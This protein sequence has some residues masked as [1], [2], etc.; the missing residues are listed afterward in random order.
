MTHPKY[1]SLYLQPDVP[2]DLKQLVTNWLESRKID[3]GLLPDLLFEFVCVFNLELTEKYSLQKKMLTM[4]DIVWVLSFIQKTIKLA[5]NTIEAYGWALWIMVVEGAA[6]YSLPHKD[7]EALTIQLKELIHRQ[8]GVTNV[9]SLE[10]LS[11]LD[12]PL[13]I[14]TDLPLNLLGLT[15]SRRIFFNPQTELSDLLG[16][17]R[18]EGKTFNWIDGDLLTAVK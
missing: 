14:T 3:A 12:F 16:Q 18:P 1:L 17:Y 8:T 15:F 10:I 5:K 13:L 6:F 2:N 7:V 4:R 9:N 11:H